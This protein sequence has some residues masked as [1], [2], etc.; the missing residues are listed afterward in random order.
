MSFSTDSARQRHRRSQPR[1][2][3]AD[4]AFAGHRGSARPHGR[5]EIDEHGYLYVQP[6][7]GWDL[8]ILLGQ[9]IVV[10]TNTGPVPG[11]SSRKAPHLLTADERKKVPEFADVWVD[12]RRPRIAV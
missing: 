7:G 5:E 2:L 11:G 1:R 6:I 9:N 8:Q 3:A 10:W 12:P 4:H